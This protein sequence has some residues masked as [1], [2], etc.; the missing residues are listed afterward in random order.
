MS[1]GNTEMAKHR[2][3]TQYENAINS[4][5]TCAL[6]ADPQSAPRL[7]TCNVGA[8]HGQGTPTY[9]KGKGG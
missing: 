7:C 5:T 1:E 2:P 3:C 4:K 8:A 9:S 6:K